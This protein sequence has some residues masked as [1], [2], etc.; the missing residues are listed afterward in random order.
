MQDGE[1]ADASLATTFPVLSSDYRPA[2]RNL[3]ADTESGASSAI[4]EPL[5]HGLERPGNKR[6]QL[7]VYRCRQ[8]SH[9]GA[10][11][12]RTTSLLG[13]THRITGRPGANATAANYN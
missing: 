13:F 11:W 10:R 3:R 12:R 1:S 9:D 6:D 5:H 4:E 2:L 7:A 8:S